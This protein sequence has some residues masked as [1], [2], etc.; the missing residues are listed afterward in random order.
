MT[1]IVIYFDRLFIFITESGIIADIS[2]SPDNEVQTMDDTTG[3]SRPSSTFLPHKTSTNDNNSH[4][5]RTP[6]DT[7]VTQKL[8][9]DSDVHTSSNPY[10]NNDSI[11]VHL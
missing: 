2:S 4:Q 11:A 3:W 9:V 6:L 5:M 10:I 1:L 8:S 7:N